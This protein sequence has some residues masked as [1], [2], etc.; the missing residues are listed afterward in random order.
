MPSLAWSAPITWPKS[1]KPHT[2]GMQSVY[3]WKTHAKNTKSW[4]NINKKNHGNVREGWELTDNRKWWNLF[5]NNAGCSP[6]L[7]KSR[8]MVLEGLKMCL[9]EWTHLGMKIR[10]GEVQKNSP[11]F[12]WN[13]TWPSSS[14]VEPPH[15]LTRA[16]HALVRISSKSR[17]PVGVIIEA[18]DALVAWESHSGS[19]RACECPC[20]YMEIT[21]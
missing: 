9:L 19:H 17:G 4:R 1:S 8:E 18:C 6:A 20:G 14:L 21:K 11:L 2:K 7:Y 16:S 10:E 12:K 3:L 5:A 15:T 13:S